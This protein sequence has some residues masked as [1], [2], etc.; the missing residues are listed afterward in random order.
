MFREWTVTKRSTI[1]SSWRE[2]GKA[3]G[4]LIKGEKVQGITGVYV[5]RK[6][7]RFL[8]RKPVP[9]FSLKAGDAILQYAEWGEGYADL[10][11]NGVWHR[12]FDWGQTEDG[13]VIL[14]DRGFTLPPVFKEGS[15]SLV[16][17][18][19]REWWVQVGRADG[20]TGWVLAQGNFGNMD[21]FGASPEVKSGAKVPPTT[22]DVPEP[23][24]PVIDYKA[25]PGEGSTTPDW[26]IQ[27]KDRMYS[28]FLDKRTMVGPLN[29]GQKV[30]ILA[31]VNVVREPDRALIRQPFE[32][33]SLERGDVVLGYGDHA[34]GNSDFWS[35]GVWFTEY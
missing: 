5:I 11:A 33:L 25:C 10:W 20:M 2:F 23:N 17:R 9:Y 3:I 8:V 18:G 35:K 16:E 12:D 14:A 26:K 30:T 1:Y 21:R 15:V 13:K 28:S 24:L 6:P 4:V 29:A 22:A 32:D 31:G 7:D 19:V 27:R 34:D